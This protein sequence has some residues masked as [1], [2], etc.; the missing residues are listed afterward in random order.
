MQGRD[1]NPQMPYHPPSS[2]FP[3]PY[4]QA[5]GPSMRTAPASGINLPRDA[6]YLIQ[7]FFSATT[8]VLPFEPPQIPFPYCVPQIVAGFDAPFARGY[9]R[10][11]DSLNLNQEQLLDFVDGLN[12]AITASPPLRVVDVSG[13]SV[14]FAPYH[15]ESIDSAGTQ[16]GDKKGS[17]R[18]LSKTL[19]DRYLRAA[20]L[21]LFR[22]RKL[23]V[24]LCTT[25]AMQ[26]LVMRRPVARSPGAYSTQQRV[27][28]LAGSAM[29][30]DF[31]VPNS[32]RAQHVRDAMVAQGVRFDAWMNA[33]PDERGYQQYDR[34]P[35]Q[36]QQQQQQ[37]GGGLPLGNGL[38]GRGVGLLGG[39]GGSYDGRG[40]GG[41][42]VG[43]LG[44]RFGGE[45]PGNRYSGGYDGGNRYGGNDGR[46]DDRDRYDDGR[47][48]RKERKRD[49]KR[50][51]RRSHDGIIHGLLGMVE[52]H[53]SGGGAG[54]QGPR[55][56]SDRFTAG[57]S[58]GARRGGLVSGL[59][60]MA[61]QSLN[62]G[63]VPDR[64]MGSS[65]QFNAAA[66][67]QYGQSE[68]GLWLVIMRFEMDRDIAGIEMAESR[69]DEEFVDERTWQA[70]MGAQ[71][72][73]V[74]FDQPL[75]YG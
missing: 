6:D 60:T 56:G 37:R 44:D 73:Q 70:E 38:I 66:D 34:S 61:G 14:A 39:G 21:R 3:P 50:E 22:P 74:A 1:T 23:S 15:W 58:G 29:P 75:Y 69:E 7:S 33:V 5:P 67:G 8:S 52:T 26:R 30:I 46:Y 59:V 25:A 41:G 43:R 40:G 57:S 49:R 4:T 9:N 13:R 32:A 27:A 72:E 48:D 63:G 36:W 47:R 10:V 68:Q 2:A 53:L 17:A 51:R 71:R 62:R 55:L 28:A 31:D 24:R 19:T 11:F 42:M 65:A 64:G 16:T 45:H 18:V 54:G 20:N 12:L 35:Q